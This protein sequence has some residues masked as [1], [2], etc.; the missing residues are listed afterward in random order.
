MVTFVFALVLSQPANPCPSISIADDDDALVKLLG[1]EE[2]ASDSPT[3]ENY[4]TLGRM[5]LELR[6]ALVYRYHDVVGPQYAEGSAVLT[7]FA[8]ERPDKFRYSEPAGDYFYDGW[9]FR[10]ILER[11]PE[12]VLVDDAAYDL[13]KVRLGGECEGWLDCY[14]EYST[15][16]LRG[17]L[18]AYPSSPLA[19]EAVS[20]VNRRLSESFDRWFERFGPPEN[21][22]VA[23]RHY[24][25]VAVARA[26]REYES[27]ALKLE[28]TLRAN[29]F[30]GAAYGWARL[31]NYP[32]ARRLLEAALEDCPEHPEAR[33]RLEA[34]PR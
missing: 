21:I 3:A 17:F 32:E 24:D 29:A 22:A 13:T 11:F 34:L 5:Y 18:D 25:P 31:E 14:V 2:A 28:P 12:S 20:E 26:L 30:V 19:A 7:R 16:R 15:N 23:S 4:L 1:C 9:H 6:E 33:P 8:K 27:T 10:Q